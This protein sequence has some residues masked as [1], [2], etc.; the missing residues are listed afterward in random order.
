MVKFNDFSLVVGGQK[1]FSGDAFSMQK[2]QMIALLGKNGAGK[3]SFLK[4]LCGLELRLQGNCQVDAYLY[5]AKNRNKIIRQFAFVPVKQAV[6]GSV[7][8][9][10]LVLSGTAAQRGFM[11][12]PNFDEVQQA[13]QILRQLGIG[14][15]YQRTFE[16][17]SD[18]EQK[19][20]LLAK[21]LLQ[22]T[23]Y[24]VLDEPEAFLDLGNRKRLFSEFKRL[25]E[26]GKSILFSTHQP[27]LALQYCTHLSCIKQKCLFIDTVNKF[28]ST[29]IE[30]I[31]GIEQ[32]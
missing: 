18:G 1:L 14:D 20:G 11:D 31:Y 17:L 12:L 25:S 15:L 28:D 19:L 22:N 32:H 21:A 6:Y 4:S 26:A 16:F 23:P 10:D 8:L 3:S 2:G 30:S 5:T 13:I 27:E 7:S 9:L 29:T 24:V